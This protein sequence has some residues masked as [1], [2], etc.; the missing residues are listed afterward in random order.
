MLQEMCCAIISLV[1]ITTAS[2]YPEAHLQ[3]DINEYPH[4][5]FYLSG[6]TDS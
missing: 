6:Q 1:L 3:E 5:D 2:I 4:Y